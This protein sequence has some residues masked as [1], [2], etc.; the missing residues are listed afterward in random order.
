MKIGDFG[1]AK[2][3]GTDTAFR[4]EGGTRS[5]VAPEVG[6]ATCGD[7]SE[8]TNAVDIWAIGCIAHE[9]L[10][11]VPPFRGLGELMS[12]CCRPEF[13]R[14]IML[15]KDISQKGIE[16]VESMLA[17][18]PERRI[19]AMEAF[20]SAWLRPPPLPF[21]PV[22][23]Q[24]PERFALSPPP[25]HSL[26]LIPPLPV[27]SP[28]SLRPPTDITMPSNILAANPPMPQ[29]S[30]EDFDSDIGKLLSHSNL[31]LTQ[32][33]QDEIENMT[34]EDLD[35]AIKKI[36]E[37][38]RATRSYRNLR[39]IE[40]F[41]TGMNEYLKVVNVFTSDSPIVAFVWVG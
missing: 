12:Y 21:P 3:A 36:Q 41:V 25:P 13:P 11:G 18:P 24:E 19:V 37:K 26:G 2:L 40:P 35:K 30:A 16:F 29:A 1:L 32:D 9:L 6:I 17:Y 14:G 7:T 28:L 5:Y 23:A 15:S 34:L 4:T 33:E 22:G 39:R 27:Q 10:T 38:Q 20:D 31:R 8:Y